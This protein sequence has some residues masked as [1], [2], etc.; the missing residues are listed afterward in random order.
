M[1]A[2]RK[3]GELSRL[4]IAWKFL[5][6]GTSWG[7][8]AGIVSGGVF[9]VFPSEL[10]SDFNTVGIGAVVGGF[11]G[12][13]IGFVAGFVLGVYTVHWHDREDLDEQKYRQAM[14]ILGGGFMFMCSG[15]GFCSLFGLSSY[16]IFPT[17]IAGLAAIFVSNQ[18]VN[19][20]LKQIDGRKKK[21][22]DTQAMPTT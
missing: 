6:Y 4:G 18:M 15:T 1:K 13:P 22:I 17:I 8:V 10:M 5:S 12:T 9:G 14:R 7:L 2:K 19:W 16:T 20:W 3:R 11:V 21:N